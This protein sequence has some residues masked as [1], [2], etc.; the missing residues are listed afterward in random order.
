MALPRRSLPAVGVVSAID[1]DHM[2]PRHPGAIAPR[3]TR[4]VCSR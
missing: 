1:A 3:W 4:E 2:L